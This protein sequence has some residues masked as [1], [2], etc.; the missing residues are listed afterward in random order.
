MT[1]LLDSNAIIRYLNGR[2]EGLRKRLDAQREETIVT[3]SVVQAELL[4]G[5][6]KSANPQK[7][8]EI[9]RR[10]LDRFRSVP[11]D[12]L[13]ARSYGPIRAYLERVGAIIGAHD[14]L[15]AAIAVAH[16]L[17]LVSHNAAEFQR[18]PG[19]RLEDWES[20]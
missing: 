9:Q 13:A 2:S 5:A 20:A 17:T 19:L 3:C 6:A 15:I 11:F 1:F 8:L 10:F 16:E 14:L 4:Y 12:D 7:A 18:V